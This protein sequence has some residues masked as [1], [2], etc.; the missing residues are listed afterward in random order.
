[1]N[2]NTKAWLPVVVAITL[3]A[4]G[5]LATGVYVK[6]QQLTSDQV[7]GSNG[8]AFTVNGARADLGTGS[9]DYWVSDGTTISSPGPVTVAALHS[10][11]TLTVGQITL[12][13]G[14]G[15]ATVASG[16]ICIC[17]DTQAV[18]ACQPSVSGTTL[19]VTVTAGGS[20]VVN[21]HCL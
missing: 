10:T 13:A 2:S 16:A 9:N 3:F 12:T 4:A 5:A 21:Y 6:G 20:N 14:T 17:N 15:T 8:L 18:I 1:M 7:S 19:T 11:S